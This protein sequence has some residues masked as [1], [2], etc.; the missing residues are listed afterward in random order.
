[1]ATAEERLAVR[2]RGLLG[3]D[4]QMQTF[5]DESAQNA[6]ID[7]AIAAADARVMRELHLT[8]NT[9]VIKSWPEE[10]AV[11][12]VEEEPYDYNRHQYR[13]Y[14][15]IS[16]RR[17]PV[18]SIERVRLML[19]PD[20]AIVEY[21]DSWIRINR[22]SGQLSVVPTPGAGWTG[23][24]L[25]N[26]A[27]YLPYLSGT[28]VEEHIPQMIAVDYTAGLGVGGE[29]GEDADPKLADL[30]LQRARLAAREILFD[31]SNAIEPGISSKSISEDGAS[32]SISYARASGKELFAAQIDR[33]EADWERFRR[34]WQDTA[35]GISFVVV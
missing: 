34:D 14:G 1:M 11:Y 30:R 18:I 31:L 29:L 2:R 17:R 7:A 26:G 10:G 5:G 4:T 8:L 23:L 35:Q 22:L 25:Q 28:V 3:L 15:Y 6:A 9:Q 12:D 24:V 13:R 21:P 19:G 20:N 16:L 33:I 27:Y 32:E